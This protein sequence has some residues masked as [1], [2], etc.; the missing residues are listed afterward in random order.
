MQFRCISGKK[1][2]FRYSDRLISETGYRNLI[3]FWGTMAESML[4]KLNSD[5]ED[6]RFFSDFLNNDNNK[7]LI[8]KLR[9]TIAELSSGY[10]G[11]NVSFLRVL[12]SNAAAGQIFDYAKVRVQVIKDEQ[13]TTVLAPIAVFFL[14]G[15]YILEEFLN[16]NDPKIPEDLMKRRALCDLLQYFIEHVQDHMALAKYR[17][18][19]EPK[20]T[21]AATGSY[22]Q[23]LL[24]PLVPEKTFEMDSFSGLEKP[25]CCPV[26]H[27]MTGEV[28]DTSFGC[29]EGWHGSVDLIINE[30]ELPVSVFGPYKHSGS[31]SSPSEAETD[32]VLLSDDLQQMMA[33]T[34]VFSFWQHKQSGNASSNCLVPGIGI[35]DEKLIVCMYDCEADVLLEALPLDIFSDHGPEILHI[36][37]VI[38]LWLLLNYKEFGNRIPDKFINYKSEFHQ[39]LGPKYLDI[40]KNKVQKPCHVKPLKE[41]EHQPDWLSAVCCEYAPDFYSRYLPQTKLKPLQL[42]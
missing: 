24:I 7:N 41:T 22:A 15:L 31:N 42:P 5:R 11:L 27:P 14:Q 19:A 23:H 16:K 33:E 2:G 4:P 8:R 17:G 34:I 6:T 38:V 3:C 26:P 40:Y 30:K 37:A 39:V 35:S 25:E 13:G 32:R 28:G 1:N 10:S 12:S 9:C 29:T 18:E 21:W 36:R 20:R